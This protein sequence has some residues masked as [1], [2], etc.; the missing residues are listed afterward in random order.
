M[1]INYSSAKII[2][3]ENQDFLE[4]YSRDDLGEEEID[5]LLGELDKCDKRNK[6]RCSYKYIDDLT[7][8]SSQS[9]VHSKKLKIISTVSWN[10]LKNGLPEE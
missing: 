7:S 6:L 1:G 2:V 10:F 4:R 8:G 9:T 3:K 5:R